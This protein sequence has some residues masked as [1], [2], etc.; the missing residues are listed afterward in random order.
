[1]DKVY[2]IYSLN[3][4]VRLIT[5]KFLLVMLKKCNIC[6]MIRSTKDLVLRE[7]GSSYMCFKCWNNYIKDKKEKSKK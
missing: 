3:F 2:L 4:S 5:I 1:M 6:G 7:D